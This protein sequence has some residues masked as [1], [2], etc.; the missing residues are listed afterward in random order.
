[1]IKK[2]F[3]K[4]VKK[5]TKA[6]ADL[7]FLNKFVFVLDWYKDSGNVG[8]L[9]SWSAIH[10]GFRRRYYR[11]GTSVC[12]RR[13]V[14]YQNLL[15]IFYIHGISMENTEYRGLFPEVHLYGLGIGKGGLLGTSLITKK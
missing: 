8:K 13:T 11:A 1:M 7:N 14:K 3:E 15:L 4:L 9:Y 5:S 2:K 12:C 10:L 6:Q